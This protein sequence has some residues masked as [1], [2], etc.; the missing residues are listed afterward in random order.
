MSIIPW[1]MESSPGVS[2]VLEGSDSHHVLCSEVGLS[3]SFEVFILRWG[4]VVGGLELADAGS[5]ARRAYATVLEILLF[6]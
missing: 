4:A 5:H 2:L 1:M 3:K 6:H